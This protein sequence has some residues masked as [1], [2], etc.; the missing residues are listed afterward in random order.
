MVE[1]GNPRGDQHAADRLG[2]SA[3]RHKCCPEVIAREITTRIL[4]TYSGTRPRGDHVDLV[5]TRFHTRRARTDAGLLANRTDQSFGRYNGRIRTEDGEH[6]AVDGLSGWAEDV[7][8][9]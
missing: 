6:V 9:L 2:I 8:M 3:S 1:R 5:F 4:S 7:R